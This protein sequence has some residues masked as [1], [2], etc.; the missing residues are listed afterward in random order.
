M[1]LGWVFN[2]C[3]CTERLPGSSN[4]VFAPQAQRQGL[5]Q[6]RVGL[7]EQQAVVQKQVQQLQMHQAAQQSAAAA[8]ASQALHASTA[9]AGSAATPGQLA[10]QPTHSLG[11]Q[12][13]QQKPGQA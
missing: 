6:A 7:Q 10:T 2:N 12:Q 3:S 4:T 13:Q 5:V 9:A 8:S 1:C 11:Q